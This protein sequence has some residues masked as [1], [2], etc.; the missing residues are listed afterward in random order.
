MT[1]LFEE[2]MA[3]HKKVAVVGL[4]YVGLPL[5]LG[6]AAKIPVLGYD[7]NPEKI[8]AYQR[9]EDPTGLH[10]PVA[11]ADLSID[12][13]TDPKAL[14]EATFFIITVPT[15]IH[16]DKRPKLV[17]V[18]AA[19]WAVGKEM[20]RGA[21]VVYVS[22]VYP[23]VTESLC[24]PMLEKV[25]G[26]REGEGFHVGYSPARTMSSQPQLESAESQAIVAATS[27][28]AAQEIAEVFSLVATG[29]IHIAR[30]IKTAEA[31]KLAENAQRD[32]NVAFMNELSM[33]FEL[34][35]VRTNDVMEGMKTKAN[36]LNFEPGLFGGHSI[37]IDPYYFIYQSEKLGF[38]PD[39]LVTARET[40][41]SMGAYVARKIIMKMIKGQYNIN[42]ETVHVLGAAY[43]ENTPD[44][45]NA[46]SKEII[47]ALS[48]YGVTCKLSDPYAN[49]EDILAR[50]GQ[51]PEQLT[52]IRDASCLVFTVGHAAYRQL[53]DED[54]RWMLRKDSKQPGI[55]IDLRRIF[56]EDHIR[57]LG[58]EYWSL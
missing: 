37:G 55:I 20:P 25:S 13:T 45:R 7:T 43:K 2:L 1:R 47:Q 18:E 17:F 11:F 56:D 35:G 30:D 24:I 8:A 27:A 32:V 39:I 54:L 53:T 50:Y 26:L 6:L 36:A 19:T 40:N 48:D 15:P 3:G 34:I 21:V 41:D 31:I 51:E 23:G 28:A 10:P 38:S 29:G 4:G 49:R 44:I 5:A 9:G 58:Y 22:T 16:E 12:F 14:A 42:R 46:K 33:Y 52:E 57:S